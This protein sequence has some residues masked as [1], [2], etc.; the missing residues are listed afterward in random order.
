[1]SY[2]TLEASIE[3]GQVVVKEADRLPARAAALLTILTPA[4]TPMALKPLKA[5]E[6]LG[7]HLKI[8]STRAQSWMQCVRDA[9]R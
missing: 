9:R 7:A 5:F 6:A 1:M 2:L 3:D 8:D 4:S